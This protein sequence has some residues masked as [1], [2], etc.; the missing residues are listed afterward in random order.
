MS[1]STQP[2]WKWTHTTALAAILVAIGVIA[3]KIPVAYLPE[4]WLAILVLLTAFIL[5]AG[6]GITG[7]WRGALIDDRNMISLSRL[8]MI[9]WT[10]LIVSAFAAAGVANMKPPAKETESTVGV[11]QNGDVSDKGPLDIAIPQ[12]LWWLMGIATTS[13]V[14]SPLIKNS[15]KTRPHNKN[16][17]KATR[18]QIC[19]HEGHAA[20][21][22]D[23]PA[24]GPTNAGQIICNKD[25]KDAR[26]ANLF[27]GEE[28][29]NGAHLDIA[30]IQLFYFSAI[31][32]LTYGLALA[33]KFTDVDTMI[34]D[35]PDLSESL[36][37]LMGISHGG[38][39]VHKAIPLSQGAAP[40]SAGGDGVAAVTPPSPNGDTPAPSPSELATPV[41]EPAQVAVAQS[42]PSP[43][44]A[45]EQPGT[46]A[47]PAGL[48]P[49]SPPQA[50]QP[51]QQNITE[52][53]YRG[54][55]IQVKQEPGGDQLTING[56][57]VEFSKDPTTHAFHTPQCPSEDFT[58]LTD[59]AKRIVDIES[60]PAEPQV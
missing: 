17:W 59:L 24:N 50:A 44:P 30:K 40:P 16:E 26:W 49:V 20:D 22:T 27:Q 9:A 60:P 55:S 57:P 2:N 19:A 46:P 35:F 38:Y 37:A 8:Q 28:T 29:G 32:V 23:A 33:H 54:R 53:T 34:T 13:L 31:G 43:S 21:S 25:P 52:E 18:A 3:V 12:E 58:S 15:K 45:Q 41:M 7:T 39:L 10:I 47:Q 11:D 5:T 1:M 51:S 36:V 56:K 4:T 6:Q 42:Q 48:I 14:G